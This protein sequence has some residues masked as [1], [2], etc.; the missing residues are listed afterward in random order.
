[1]NKYEA[2]N[3]LFKDIDFR[4]ES[5][6]KTDTESLKDMVKVLESKINELE[7]YKNAIEYGKFEN[8]SPASAGRIPNKSVAFKD[9]NDSIYDLDR[10]RT[11][12]PWYG[13]E[14]IEPK[15]KGILRSLNNKRFEAC[16]F[17]GDKLNLER[18]G[19]NNNDLKDISYCCTD[20]DFKLDSSKI[21]SYIDGSRIDGAQVINKFQRMVIG[22]EDILDD[23]EFMYHT[24]LSRKKCS[25]C[26][27]SLGKVKIFNFISI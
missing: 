1:M 8:K 2:R 27:E 3:H 12:T 15:S 4:V 6:L 24:S 16:A 11:I 5:I 10:F 7:S 25:D 9:S 26:H 17:C 14:Q 18:Y 19:L 23:Y 22:S 20:C 13:K 21:D